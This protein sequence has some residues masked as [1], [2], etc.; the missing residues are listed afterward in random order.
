MLISDLDY[1]NTLVD[2]EIDPAV[3]GGFSNSPRIPFNYVFL[4][5]REFKQDKFTGR[6]RGGYVTNSNGDIIGIFSS[7]K[8]SSSSI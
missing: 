1:L 3:K 6:S 4:F 7:S 8:I 2:S 5:D